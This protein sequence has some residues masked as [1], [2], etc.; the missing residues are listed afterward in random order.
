V[1]THRLLP[2]LAVTLGLGLFAASCSGAEGDAGSP[3]GDASD[4]KESKLAVALHASLPVDEVS[5]LGVRRVG[6][7]AEYLAVADAATTVLTFDVDSAGKASKITKHDLSR[8]V[9]SAPSQWEAVAGDGAGNVFVLAEGSDTISVLAPDLGRLVHSIHLDVPHG[10]PL[11]DAWRADPNSHGEGMV[12]LAN[13]HVL[14]VKEKDPVAVIELAATGEVA[15]GYRAD[16]ALGDRAFPLPPGNAATLT[17]L[18]HWVLKSGDLK[19]VGD[20]SELALD[21]DGRLLLLSD[22]GRAIVRVERDLRPDED[23]LDL[24]TVFRLPSAVDKP[25]GLVL[26]AGIP[27]VAVDRKGGGDSLFTLERMR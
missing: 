27:L 21:V 8:V 1:T 9:G 7:K 25:E 13:G 22:Q 17:A 15:Q 4:L 3:A 6:G 24:K 18:H 12:L 2:A 10:S 11:D 19:A 23:K 26:A 20:V 14:V 16:L 5:G